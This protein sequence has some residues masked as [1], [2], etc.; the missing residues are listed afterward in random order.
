MSSKYKTEF[1]EEASKLSDDVGVKTA[2]EQLGLSYATLC[3][4]WSKRKRYG[5]HA[6]VGSGHQYQST[7][8]M[9]P[10]EIELQREIAE[11][12]RAN[13]ILKDALG[14]SAKDRK[15]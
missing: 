3:S 4:W 10:R 15:K 11:L 1:K 9:S 13:D 6:F 5:E 7:E 12:R 8:G 14:F 2:A